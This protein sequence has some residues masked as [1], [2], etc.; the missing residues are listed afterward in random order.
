M[1]SLFH[2]LSH[3]RNYT[4][5]VAGNIASNI[6][7]VFFSVVSIPAI[8]PFLNILLGQQPLVRTPPASP[9]RFSNF[10][11]W[12]NYYL[13]QI[14]LE[15]GEQRALLY[16]CGLIVGI[17]FFRNIFRYASLFF[18]APVRNGIVRDLRQSLFDKMLSLPIAWFSE[19]RKGDLLSRITSDVQEVEWSILNFLE[20]IVREPLLIA[21]SLGFMLYV[22]PS[23]TVFVFVL[24]LFMALV[25]GGIGKA[26]KKQ[27]GEV[28]DRLGELV[29]QVEETIS[30][31]RIIKGFNA[32]KYQSAK[33]KRSNDAYR[34]LLTR[35]LWRKD[36]SSPLTEFLGVATVAVLIWYGYGEVHSG[37]ISVATFIAFLYA[38]F[39][40]IEPSKKFSTAFYNI[41]KGM[42]AL[43]RTDKIRLADNDIREAPD[44]RPVRAFESEIRF[45]Q[46]SFQYQNDD[47]YVLKN[48]NLTI[49]RGKIIALVGMS[50]AGKTTLADLMPRFYDPVGGK[51][52]L[53]GQDLRQLRVRDL[54]NLFGIVPQE[55]VLFNDTIYN[56]IVFGMENVRREDVIRAARIANAHDFILQTEHGY[57]TNIGDRGNKLSGG[58][59]QR[60]TIAR[61]I[62]KNPP[63][64][65]LDEATSS[66]DSE[67]ERLVREALEKL[68]QNRT[69]VVIAHRLSTVQHADCIVVMRA[70]EI[71]E[72]GTHAELI[73]RQGEY[74][75]LVELQGL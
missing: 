4:G 26:L 9:L 74:R 62:L 70:G 75:K 42:A 19:A 22:S 3:L 27:S 25:I 51:I 23:L 72:T 6:L 63:I 43:E 71:I 69:A 52:L 45:E 17:Y 48:I 31:L 21:G 66:L 73:A 28:Q 18:M 58:Q 16:A 41:R 55:A 57:E 39:S 67:S 54:R 7:M 49:P 15:Y 50:G 61:A 2:L 44:A 10:P 65:I 12:F 38:F 59:R 32:E 20:V 68:L 53:D 14:I 64:L 35:L 34:R 8:I 37:K 11:D 29:A 60:L 47:K 33:F 1:R 5:F 56:N 24:L 46:V 13:S 40:M 36:L 30:G